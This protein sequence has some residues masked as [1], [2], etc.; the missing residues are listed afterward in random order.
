MAGRCVGVLLVAVLSTACGAAVRSGRAQTLSARNR[1]PPS[2][3]GTVPS[4]QDLDSGSEGARVCAI[5][6]IDAAS[7]MVDV[8]LRVEPEALPESRTEVTLV[9][10]GETESLGR[11]EE[12][13]EIRY[14][15]ELG[16]AEGSF[17]RPGGWHVAGRSI[18]PEIYIDGAAA[19]VAA[20]LLIEVDLP[21][22]TAAGSDRRV[23]DAPSLTRLANESYEIGP[24]AMTRRDVEDVTLWIG[25]SSM[26]DGAL[27][28]VA[29]VLA[30]A[31]RRLRD[32]LGPSPTDTVLI[33]LHT[34]AAPS[35]AR[36][37]STV[38]WSMAPGADPEVELA[39]SLRPLAHLW[40]PGTRVIAEAW[41]REGVPEHYAALVANAMLG[42]QADAFARGVVR[43]WSRYADNAE[44]R[45]LRSGDDAWVVDAGAVAGFCLDG[46]LRESSSSLDTVLRRTL[47]RDGET[48]STESLLEDLAALAPEAAGHLAAL[49]ET[50]GA[51]AIDECLEHQGLT[52]RET[53]FRSWTDST[54][55]EI[56]G[57]TLSEVT[58]LPMLRVDE[59]T[60]GSPLEAGDLVMR[61]HGHPTSQRSD[62]AWALRD[63]SAGDRV[64]L[65]VHRSGEARSLERVIPELDDAE[66]GSEHT[67]LELLRNEAAP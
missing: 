16:Q 35:S 60:E 30:D 39:S 25:S 9:R 63:V 3:N 23:F 6:Q 42:G 26:P 59:S 61:V 58:S 67:Y 41:L 11:V 1:P 53:S 31:F 38:V 45:T 7:G 57:A 21:L 47:A 8:F 55:N 20:T 44:G 13:T 52:T 46:A 49:V 33:T 12:A 48:L 17:R 34:S 4:C 24:L 2:A 51:F 10:A 27:E 18:L 62:V 22:F 32:H 66:R 54:L 29:D 5:A 14:R 50:S 43:S 64:E 15:V 19:S 40:V 56:I 28:G 65:V 37:G 36:D